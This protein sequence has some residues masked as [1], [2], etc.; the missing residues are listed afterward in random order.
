MLQYHTSYG[1]KIAVTID[2][3]YPIL[4]EPLKGKKLFETYC[5]HGNFGR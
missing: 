3:V 5:C 1:F 4:S 2:M